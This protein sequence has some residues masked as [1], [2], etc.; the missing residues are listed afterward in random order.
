MFQQDHLL[1]TSNAVR[2]IRNYLQ[3]IPLVTGIILGFLL[4][5][6]VGIFRRHKAKKP[7]TPLS[8]ANSVPPSTHISK[9]QL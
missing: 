9:K 8:R 7:T 6:I 3:P 2:Q 1:V 4:F 5:G